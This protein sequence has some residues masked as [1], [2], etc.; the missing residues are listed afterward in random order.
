MFFLFKDNIIKITVVKMKRIL[1]VLMIALTGAAF[2]AEA[3][4][5]LKLKDGS[6]IKGE[7]I[8]ATGERMEFKTEDGYKGSCNMSDVVSLTKE[9]PTEEEMAQAEA[10]RRKAEAE[11]NYVFSKRGYRTQI[12]LV[13]ESGEFGTFGYDAIFGY[14]FNSHLQLGGG[15]GVRYLSDLSGDFGLPLYVDFKANLFKTKVTPFINLKAG[16]LLQFGEFGTGYYLSPSVGVKRHFSKARALS[17]STG[18]AI[19]E[20]VENYFYLDDE[21]YAGCA[22]SFKI[23]YQF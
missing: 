8:E 13:L 6:V 5:V 9:P 7:L 4:D 12:E 2:T 11:K 15:V 22:F 16:T 17:V 14:Q 1:V 20:C 18:L 10:E 23:N 3:K 21:Y 19:A